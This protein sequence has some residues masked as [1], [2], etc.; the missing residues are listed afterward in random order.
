MTA[1]T[2]SRVSKRFG[3]VYALKEVSLTCES[4]E[5]VGLIGPNGAGKTTLLNVIASTFPLDSGEVR[6]AEKRIDSTSPRYCALAGIARTFQ[7]IRLFDRLSV[8]QNVEVSLTTSQR[9]RRDRLNGMT[10]HSILERLELERVANRKANELP[11]GQQRRLEIARALALVPEFLLL[12]EPAAGMNE[13]ESKHLISSVQAIRDHA[14]CGIIVVDHDLRFIL[15]VCERI[16]VLHM[17]ELI[18]EGPPEEVQKNPKVIEV[19]I[20]SRRAKEGKK[21]AR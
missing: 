14:K 5:I 10:V 11:Y 18:A 4:G 1:L 12:D 9:Y 19:Y 20:G 7:N 17:G 13:V 16:Y 6:L 8:R 15:N 2:V 21:Q 3:G